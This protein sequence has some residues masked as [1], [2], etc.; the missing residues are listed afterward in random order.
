M[1]SPSVRNVQSFEWTQRRKD[2]YLSSRKMSHEEFK[3]CVNKD[4]K[5][6]ELELVCLLHYPSTIKHD[7]S[8]G[9]GLDGQK[10]L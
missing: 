10:K 3:V 9:N 4:A 7:I 6:V 2:L 1:V 8:L 5:K